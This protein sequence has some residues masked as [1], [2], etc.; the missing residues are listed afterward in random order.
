MRETVEW[1]LSEKDRKSWLILPEEEGKGKLDMKGPL[2]LVKVLLRT[3]VNLITTL[4]S[5]ATLLHF[6]LHISTVVTQSEF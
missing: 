6:N 1:Q 3:G 2:K 4:A 5:Y